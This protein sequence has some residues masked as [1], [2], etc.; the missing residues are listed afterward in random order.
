MFVKVSIWSPQDEQQHA[1]S[2]TGQ[3]VCLCVTSGP[4]QQGSRGGDLGGTLGGSPKP[5]TQ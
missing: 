1:P 2:E 4:I 3:R 5:F